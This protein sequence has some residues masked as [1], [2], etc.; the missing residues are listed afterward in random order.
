MLGYGSSYQNFILMLLFSCC[1]PHAGIYVL[2]IMLKFY[3]VTIGRSMI[4]IVITKILVLRC[5]L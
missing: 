1:G 5:S 3:Y 4:L 2:L